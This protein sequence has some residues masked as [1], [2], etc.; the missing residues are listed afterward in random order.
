VLASDR[1]AAYADELYDLCYRVRPVAVRDHT[2]SVADVLRVRRAYLNYLKVET[3]IAAH[4]KH[5]N[6][7]GAKAQRLRNLLDERERRATKLL[8][9]LNTKN[10][11]PLFA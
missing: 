10:L 5:S 8:D 11:A 1:V 3:S 6:D 7:S 9:A 4:S 2:I